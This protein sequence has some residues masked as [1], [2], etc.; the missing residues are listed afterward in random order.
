MLYVLLGL[1][2]CKLW[3]GG[4]AVGTFW[5]G[6]LALSFP[7]ATLRLRDVEAVFRSALS[8]DLLPNGYYADPGTRS[9]LRVGLGC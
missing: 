2:W 5:R 8:L 3:V 7:G 6:R 1:W 9:G 4:G